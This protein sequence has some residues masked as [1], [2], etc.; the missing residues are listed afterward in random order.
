MSKNGISER[1]KHF[2][3]EYIDSVEQLDV[4]LFIRLNKDKT[5]NCDNIAHEIRSSSKSVSTRLQALEQTG[6]LE[7]D[8]Q[9][10][11]LFKYKMGSADTEAT[12]DDLAEIYKLKKQKVLELIFS[13]LKK[14]R[15]FANAFKVTGTKREEEGEDG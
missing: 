10:T 8:P 14:S 3:F 2:I 1:V 11:Q 13:P 4:L 12:L 15:H 7:K 5:W 6:F 9:N